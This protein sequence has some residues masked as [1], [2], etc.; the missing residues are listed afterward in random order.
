MPAFAGGAGSADP[1]GAA[2]AAQAAA[3]KFHPYDQEHEHREQDDKTDQRRTAHYVQT[4]GGGRTGADS[5]ARP[6][7]TGQDRRSGA[8]HPVRTYRSHV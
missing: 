1:V 6:A 8:A 7:L 5:R 3:Q 4:P 2:T